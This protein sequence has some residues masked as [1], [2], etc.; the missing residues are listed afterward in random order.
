MDTVRRMGR[1]AA[2]L[3]RDAALPVGDL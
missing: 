3:E 1:C 2:A